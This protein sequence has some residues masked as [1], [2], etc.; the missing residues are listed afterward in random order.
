M[1]N[2]KSAT[3]AILH[4]NNVL[5]LKR[6]DSAPWMP[7][8]FCLPGGRLETNES[9]EDCALREV[10]EETNI[11]L[12]RDSLVPFEIKYKN[13]RTK[14]V[15]ASIVSS[16]IVNLN[17]EHSD[18]KWVSFDNINNYKLVPRLYTTLLVISKSSLACPI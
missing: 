1:N 18:Y 12:V 2:Q 7:G 5:L 10:Y 13:N 17:W 15:F 6:G 4:N 8:R 3:V 16:D 14:I 9:L 11:V